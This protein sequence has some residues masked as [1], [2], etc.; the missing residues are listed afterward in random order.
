MKSYAFR[1]IAR[2][3]K[4]DLGTRGR[5]AAWMEAGRPGLVSNGH[6]TWSRA[7]TLTQ[8]PMGSLVHHIGSHGGSEKPEQS[9]PIQH[10]QICVHIWRKEI[11]IC[12]KLRTHALE[13]R[14]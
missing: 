7:Y 13:D 6:E 5:R 8:E 11:L 14:R 4:L 9:G 3:V 2:W 12:T 10:N 1:K